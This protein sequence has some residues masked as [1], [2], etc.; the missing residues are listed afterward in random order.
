M[1][2][3][4][5]FAGGM[6]AETIRR[7]MDYLNGENNRAA[8]NG[9]AQ[10]IRNPVN[11]NNQP[12]WIA[13][14]YTSIA[15]YFTN[16]GL[17]EAGMGLR[18]RN[19]W[20]AY[21][22]AAAQM[23]QVALDM[24][25]TA[26]GV[27]GSFV[28]TALG[29]PSLVFRSVRFS[30]SMG[31]Y[32]AGNVFKG[33]YKSVSGLF[34]IIGFVLRLPATVVSFGKN[35]VIGLFIAMFGMTT[36]QGIDVLLDNFEKIFAS[37]GY[38]NN[39]Q[40]KMAQNFVKSLLGIGNSLNFMLEGAGEMVK[41]ISNNTVVQ[42]FTYYLR[43]A[44]S[45]STNLIPTQLPNLSVP[46]VATDENTKTLLNDALR[47]VFVNTEI[48]KVVLEQVKTE[49]IEKL[50]NL[51]QNG[52]TIQEKV[53]DFLFKQGPAATV[54]PDIIPKVAASG[55]PLTPEAEKAFQDIVREP[56]IQDFIENLNKTAS[57]SPGADEP[58]I[59]TTTIGAGIGAGKATVNALS[60]SF[61]DGSLLWWII[62][63]IV[64]ILAMFA[65]YKRVFEKPKQALVVTNDGEK[66]YAFYE[67]LD[68]ISDRYDIQR[69]WFESLKSN[70]K[71]IKK[72]IP[73]LEKLKMNTIMTN[74]NKN[75]AE[76][77]DAAEDQD[78]M[79]ATA[80]W[81]KNIAFDRMEAEKFVEK[82]QSSSTKIAAKE[83]L[84]NVFAKIQVM[85]VENTNKYS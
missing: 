13:G 83:D 72:I 1:I 23:P 21:V 30:L 18:N 63:I 85:F 44:Y 15:V 46:D 33:I 68:S 17:G 22:P 79:A 3:N 16:L 70:K 38:E 71:N 6:P 24:L 74:Y 42:D 27:A 60:G 65:T 32:V 14:L 78:I 58:N 59:F 76:W 67:W 81:L 4:R 31:S 19:F 29:V 20:E 61:F 7:I 40:I 51:P 5:I 25:P 54:I 53:T 69:E 37:L 35:C 43:E 56:L 2:Y 47:K 11:P 9:P 73:A 55:I 41:S 34:D 66:V 28:G 8:G 26:L 62:G 77:V 57:S 75:T 45:K 82:F 10:I 39:A 52:T 12:N 84:D 80:A 36:L 48:P 49:N 64:S 50:V